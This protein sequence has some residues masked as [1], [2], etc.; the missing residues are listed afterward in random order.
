MRKLILWC[1]SL[2]LG[3]FASVQ[4]APILSIQGPGSFSAGSSA[5][6]DLVISGLNSTQQVGAFD[7]SLSWDPAVLALTG[8]AFDVFL[9]GPSLSLQSATAGSGTINLA[10]TS[11]GPLAAQTGLSSF[12]LASVTFSGISPGTSSL[13]F[14]PG[15]FSDGLGELLGVDYRGSRTTVT[16]RISVSEPGAFSLFAVAA[17]ALA[18]STRRR[19]LLASL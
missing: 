8:S 13:A 11:F 12:R 18:W 6:F 2:V 7:F 19:R 15:V 10:E 4:A 16:P 9:D 5:S 14:T 3:A 17:L 1:G